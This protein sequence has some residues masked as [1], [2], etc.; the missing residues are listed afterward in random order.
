MASLGTPTSYWKLD[1]ASGNAADSV[2]AN[3]LTNNNTV[4]Y[5]SSATAGSLNNCADFGTANANKSLSI[6]SDL[7]WTGGAIS[8]SMWIKVRT[9]I[10]S[11]LYRIMNLCDSGNHVEL[12]FDYNYNGGTKRLEFNR[13]KI[14]VADQRVTTNVS[15]GILLWHHLVITYDNTNVRGYLNGTLVGTQAA[16]GNGNNNAETD[17]F[18]IG[19]NKDLVNNPSSIY[20]DEVCVKVGAAWDATEVAYL[21]N[22]GT[23]L[24]YP[25]SI[26][27]SKSETI[28]AT[29][30][31]T[32]DRQIAKTIAETITMSDEFA[33]RSEWTRRAKN[34]S[35]VWTKRS[36]T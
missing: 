14:L 17:T 24:P 21:Y 2:G 25:F 36:K 35:G 16:S 20:A 15:L 29:E 4:G 26:P 23:P 18:V 27:Y 6:A 28:T 30:T 12:I 8:V 13:S 31:L 10:T 34:T 5:A 1:E 33:K 19:M 9:E 7:G 11:G 3:T 22:G 32:K